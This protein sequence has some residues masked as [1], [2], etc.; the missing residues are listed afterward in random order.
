MIKV[1]GLKIGQNPIISTCKMEFEVEIESSIFGL[2]FKKIK[3]LKCKCSKL[4]S[5]VNQLY[6]I[7]S[8]EWLVHYIGRPETNKIE[9]KLEEYIK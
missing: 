9:H 6:C 4:G 8:G 5:S 7:D 2:F 3:T 1:I